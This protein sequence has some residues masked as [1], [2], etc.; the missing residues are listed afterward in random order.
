[1]T[2]TATHTAKLETTIA[3]LQQDLEQVPAIDAIPVLEFWQKQ[4]PGTA[5]AQTLEKL[6]LALLC[7]D[8]L[9]MVPEP[10][11]QELAEQTDKLSTQLNPSVYYQV[12]QIGQ[13]LREATA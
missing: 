3:F 1:M 10:I 2:N 9:C 13:L 7:G 12:K 4:L 8:R 5:I 11:L 6:K